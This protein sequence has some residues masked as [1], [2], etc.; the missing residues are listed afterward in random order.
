MKGKSTE[1][2]RKELQASGLSGEALEK[3]LPHK[4]GFSSE[5]AIVEASQI[6][7][8]VH[9][10]EHQPHPRASGKERECVAEICRL[11]NADL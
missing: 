2:A 11:S 8:A 1:E 10:S 7:D 3:I 6:D 5:L 9:C 4:A